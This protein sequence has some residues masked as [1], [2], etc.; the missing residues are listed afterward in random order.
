MFLSRMNH[1]SRKKIMIAQI[2]LVLAQEALV[3]IVLR[4]IEIKS[5]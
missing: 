1:L 4:V 5:D 2:L 3:A